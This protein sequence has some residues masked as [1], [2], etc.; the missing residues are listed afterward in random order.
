MA[1]VSRVG[2]SAVPVPH[3]TLAW[4][5]G[6]IGLGHGSALIETLGRHWFEHWAHIGIDPG[7]A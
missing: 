6:R 7:E 5:L 2:A 4:A 1:G 3:P